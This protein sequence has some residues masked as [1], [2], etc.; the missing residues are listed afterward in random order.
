ML[1]VYA[2]ERCYADRVAAAVAEHETTVWV[3]S[4][5]RLE[6][7]IPA[8]T[9]AVVVLGWLRGT[10]GETRLRDL[11]FRHPFHP[12]VLVTSKNADNAL[13]IRWV[14]VEEVVWLSDVERALWPA[15]RRGPAQV[16]LQQ[17]AVAVERALPS[18]HLLGRAIAYACRAKPPLHSIGQLASALACDRRTLWRH[19]RV[20]LAGA[21]PLRLEDLLDWFLL[22]HAVGRKLPG[23]SWARLATELQV[24]PH[25]LGRIAARLAGRPLRTLT[26]ADQISLTVRCQSEFL[27]ALLGPAAAG[28]GGAS[29]GTI[30]QS[31]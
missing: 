16:L 12:L 18:D 22:L 25:T 9:C 6:E 19:W 29:H 26:A 24:H 13:A 7:T 11:R 5:E 17:V 15:V 4:W 3:N 28:P 21:A 10:A 14:A 2:D 23:H 30:A 20:A 8:T 1:A 31:A 27:A